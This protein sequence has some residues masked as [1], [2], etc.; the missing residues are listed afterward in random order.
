M[1]R[2]QQRMRAEKEEKMR[3]ISEGIITEEKTGKCFIIYH[4]E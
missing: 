4:L 3:K 2:R 1:L